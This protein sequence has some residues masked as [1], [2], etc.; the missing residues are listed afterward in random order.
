M[1]GTDAKPYLCGF[2]AKCAVEFAT[3]ASMDVSGPERALEAD[4][5]FARLL[6][7]GHL[8]VP[9]FDTLGQT[10][11]LIEPGLMFKLYPICSSAQALTEQSAMLQTEHG[12]TADDIKHIRCDVPT[13]LARSLVYDAPESPRPR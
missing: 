13:L 9:V 2:N 1:F 7:E 6:N 11:R 8:D 5:G 3:A 10:W 12:F 4:Y